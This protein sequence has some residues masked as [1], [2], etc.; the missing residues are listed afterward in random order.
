MLSSSSLSQSE[1]NA[2]LPG[3]YLPKGVHI[4]QYLEFSVAFIEA[5]G[6]GGE[7]GDGVISANCFPY[8]GVR[9]VDI[10]HATSMAS[11]VMLLPVVDFQFI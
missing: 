4:T 6:D 7:G 3:Q 9:F 5:A 11:W 8:R 1:D 2:N 10:V